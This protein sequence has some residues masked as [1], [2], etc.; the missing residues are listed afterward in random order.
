MST[1]TSFDPGSGIGGASSPFSG[2]VID[3]INQTVSYQGN[4]A[5]DAKTYSDSKEALT[6]N[7]AVRYEESYSVNLD[8]ELAFLVQL[9]NAYSANARVMQ[10]IKELQDELLSVVR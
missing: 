1:T 7:L 2:T 8:E 3:Y 10:I 4:Q 5:A 9:Q 6:S